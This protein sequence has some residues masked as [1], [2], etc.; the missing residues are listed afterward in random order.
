MNDEKIRKFIRLAG[1]EIPE[2][3]EV[4]DSDRRRLGAQLLLSEVLE[5]V[6]KGLG[7]TPV[8]N[9]EPVTDAN[10]LE[11]R[12]SDVPPD[13]LEMLDGLA[14]VAYTMFWNS[15]S[16]AAPLNEAFERVCDNN[17]EKFV[18]L[19]EWKDKSGALPSDKWEKINVCHAENK[20]PE[21]PEEVAS[22][23]IVEHESQ[24]YAVGKDESGK[25]R[26]PSTYQSVDLRSLC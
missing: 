9:G 23:E 16:F 20:T 4:G 12:I 11:Y 24:H 13:K 22:V 6:I 1:Q 10:G 25:V 26:K 7:V 18:K 17:L 14:D 8:V 3:F 21:W 2:T 19:K 15:V 5:Y